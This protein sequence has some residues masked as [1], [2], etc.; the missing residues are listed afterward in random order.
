MIAYIYFLPP[1]TSIGVYKKIEDQI[2]DLQNI[3]TARLKIFIISPTIEK[4]STVAEYRKYNTSSNRF[5]RLL[6]IAFRKFVVIEKTIPELKKFN[7]I[8]LRYPG[9]D[10]TAGSFYKKHNIVTELHSI[11]PEELRMKFKDN[12]TLISKFI[13]AIRILQEEALFKSILCKSKGIIT[14]SGD[15]MDYIQKKKINSHVSVIGNGISLSRIPQKG[16]LPYNGKDITLTFIGSRPAEPQNGL[17]RLISS[18]DIE[19]QKK[20]IT[21]N[22]IGKVSEGE[23]LSANYINLVY[24]GIQSQNNINTILESTNACICQ[25]AF[26]KKRLNN[27]S[28]IKV[29]EY[30][31]YG[32]PFILAYSDN[33]LKKKPRNHYY[34]QL[35]NND[36]LIK[37]EEIISFLTNITK[38][39]DEIINEMYAF[40]VKYL[41]WSNK[42]AQYMHFVDRINTP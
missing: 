36:E 12:K 20:N 42:L 15:V 17:N 8:I 2:I 34:L 39:R 19:D 40:A 24:H 10:F 30:T 27:T 11:V 6:Q 23:K 21:I 37:V 14:V 35:D 25:L 41:T 38:K 4:S 3:A 33:N 31:A 16:F 5:F 32:I 22:V 9:A 18:L 28:T 7:T 26:Y 29:P 1:K 13:K